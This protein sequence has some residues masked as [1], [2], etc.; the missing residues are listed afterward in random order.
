MIEVYNHGFEVRELCKI[1]AGAAFK[2]FLDETTHILILKDNFSHNNG[3][4]K[5]IYL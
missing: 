3:S 5:F 1:F 4:Q 2:R